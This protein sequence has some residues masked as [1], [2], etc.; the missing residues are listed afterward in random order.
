ML[1]N[2]AI[3]DVEAFSPSLATLPVE[4]NRIKKLADHCLA[5]KG[6][7][8]KRSIFQLTTTAA[9]FLMSCTLMF[10]AH[11]K[12]YGWLNLLLLL[13]T[14]GFLVRLFIIQHDCGHGSFFKSRKMNDGAG[15]L[16]SVL[17][18]MPYSFWMK[19]HNMHHASSGNLH[20]RG[21]G[22][23]ETL[24]VQEYQALP[25]RKQIAYRIYR[26]P[27]ILLLLATPFHALIL[28]RFP[29]SFPSALVENYRALSFAQIWKSVL[30]LDA[31]ILICYGALSAIVGLKAVLLVYLPILIVTTWIGGW[32][33]FIQHQFEEAYWE[34][35]E[36]WN[37]Q[38]AS[39]LGSSY[40]ALPR[41][42]QWFTGNIGLHHIHHL[43]SLIPNYRL[44]ECLDKNED[45]KTLNRMTLRESFAC[46]S[47][48]LWDE[49]QKKMVGFSQIKAA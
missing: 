28:Q 23:I 48:A 41:L 46:L 44:Q 12:G 32:L 31:A 27:A 26:A 34:E 2:A 15:R 21:L 14:A 35:N 24:T 49:D 22:S 38:E 3:Q 20:R 13:P 30:G 25:L 29:S 39:V 18:F 19:A 43:C 45:L 4:E 47:W 42:L 33:F 17:T 7:D 6:A 9:L 37:F 40:Y 16:I 36:N 1:I 5:Y 10:V 11:A 8:V